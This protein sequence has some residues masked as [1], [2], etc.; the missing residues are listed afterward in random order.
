[1]NLACAESIGTARKRL[2]GG[3]IGHACSARTS[4][5]LDIQNSIKAIKRRCASVSLGLGIMITKNRS[6]VLKRPLTGKA[7]E[8]EEVVWMPTPETLFF[9]Q[10]TFTIRPKSL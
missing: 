4:P 7:E 5:E 1:M 8:E 6:Y 9:S 2:K 10:K 3:D